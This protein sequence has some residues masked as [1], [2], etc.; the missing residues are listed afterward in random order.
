MFDV[1]E[2][3]DMNPRQKK[4]T[5]ASALTALWL[6]TLFVSARAQQPAQDPLVLWL[7]RI[8]QQQ[9]KRREQAIAEIRT[10]AD[11][12]KRKAMGAGENSRTDRWAA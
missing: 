3:E 12:E 1:P 7:D 9:L 11:A 10:V 6:M 2:A 5:F 8:A 4:Y